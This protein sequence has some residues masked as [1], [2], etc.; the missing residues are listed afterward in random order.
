MSKHF[1][2]NIISLNKIGIGV[3]SPNNA[4]EVLST[5]TQQK[6]SYDGSNK[7]L[8]VKENINPEMNC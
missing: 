2:D 4:L 3:N 1:F 8:Y 6:W 5:S 7:P